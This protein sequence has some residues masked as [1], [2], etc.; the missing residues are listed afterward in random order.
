M[1]KEFDIFYE[2]DLALFEDR[3]NSDLEYDENK[4]NQESIVYWTKV[5]LIIQDDHKNNLCILHKGKEF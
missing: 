2:K 5:I 3:N 1:S 4:N